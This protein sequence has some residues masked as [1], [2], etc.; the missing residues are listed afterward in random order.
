M[1]RY[2]GPFKCAAQVRMERRLTATQPGIV[3][4]TR[5][6]YYGC[7]APLPEKKVRAGARLD[8]D[9]TDVPPP[10]LAWC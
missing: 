5:C 1:Q 3:K 7:L 2:A 6:S 4:L 8:D 10:P 9:A